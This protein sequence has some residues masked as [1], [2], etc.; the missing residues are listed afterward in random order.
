MKTVLTTVASVAVFLCVTF[1]G[2]SVHHQTDSLTKQQ[3]FALELQKCQ[4]ASAAEQQVAK[5]ELFGKIKLV[6]SFP[7]V[8]VKAVGSFPD[9]KVKV[10]ESFADSPG[11]WKIVQS[12]PDYKVQ[13]VD[14][15]PDYKIKFVDAFPGCK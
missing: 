7:D 3:R 6:N 1:T 2:L 14:A 15:F 13:F 5:C 4:E 8:K 12:F 9:I 10:V 11:E